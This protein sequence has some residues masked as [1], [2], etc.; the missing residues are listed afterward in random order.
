MWLYF[1]INT[2]YSNLAHCTKVCFIALVSPIGWIQGLCC[3]PGALT[4][5]GVAYK[6]LYSGEK[7]CGFLL[8]VI[9][10]TE[11]WVKSSE[12]KSQAYPVL[13]SWIHRTVSF[14]WKET[15]FK[16]K[17]QPK[18]NKKISKKTTRSLWWE[19]INL[20]HSLMFSD[21]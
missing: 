2:E 16:N 12:R 1:I 3:L 10:V 4:M 13:L 14:R 9:Q 20:K 15:V 18:I 19:I 17:Q 7:Y 5:L 8:F 21:I 11:K 6:V